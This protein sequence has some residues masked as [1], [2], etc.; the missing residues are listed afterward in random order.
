MNGKDVNKEIWKFELKPHIQMPKGAQLLSVAVQQGVAVI[1][2]L[3]DPNAPRV[4][5]ELNIYMTGFPI[6]NPGRFLGTIL[7]E[8][9]TYVLHVFDPNKEEA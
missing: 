8:N 5:R 9:G 3:V 1:W 2:A 6:K 4:F 7:E